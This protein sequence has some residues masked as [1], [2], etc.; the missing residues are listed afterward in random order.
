MPSGVKNLL[1]PEAKRGIAHA[2]EEKETQQPSKP[3]SL[4]RLPE[5]AWVWP[6][7]EWRDIVGPCSDAPDEYHWGI[8]RAVLGLAVGRKLYIRH[9]KRLFPNCY[10]LLIGPARRN[11]KSTCLGFGLDLLQKM[12][13]K[14]VIIRHPESPKRIYDMLSKGEGKPGLLFQDEFR[15]LLAV[16]H[17]PGTADMVSRLNTLYYCPDEDTVGGEKAI[18]IKNSFISLITG[19]PLAWL[20][21]TFHAGDITGG[22]MGRFMVIAGERKPYMPRPPHPDEKKIKRLAQKLEELV[23]SQPPDGLCMDWTPQATQIWDP[24]AT[25]TDADLNAVP[26]HITSLIGGIEEHA[27]K[28]A[29]L[30]SFVAEAKH[31]TPQ[32]TATAIQVADVLKQNTLLTLGTVHL[33]RQGKLEE[34]IL[35]FAEGNN[36]FTF[37]DLKDNLGSFWSREGTLHTLDTLTRDGSL[38]DD[39]GSPARGKRGHRWRLAR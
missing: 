22:F 32:A 11:R 29:M 9:P 37:T 39:P 3:N 1:T 2:V 30:Y 28:D 19:A 4:K 33:N 21:D 35:K 20:E 5:S 31:L 18:E 10:M 17:R 23:R 14:Y 7:D 36:P 6:Y 15:G 38:E 13:Q 24:W 16:G 26:E 12:G 25:R 34:R 8:M 27:I